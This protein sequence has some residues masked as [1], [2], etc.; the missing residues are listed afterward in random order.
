MLGEV[1]RCLGF[2]LL[3]DRGQEII[4]VDVAHKRFDAAAADSFSQTFSLSASGPDGRER[5]S[6]QFMSRCRRMKLSTIAIECAPLRKDRAQWPIR[7][8]RRH[9]VQL[10]SFFLHIETAPNFLIR[11]QR[12]ARGK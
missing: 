9:Q 5:L 4:V 6:A 12:T 2:E 7:S 11:E 8:N 10:F 3:E 1:R